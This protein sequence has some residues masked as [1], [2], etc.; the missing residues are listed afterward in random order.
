M[1][2]SAGFTLIELVVVI[3]LLG[4]LAAVAVPK[5]T[6]L[7][8]DARNAAAAG[9][10]GAI[11]SGSAINYGSYVAR[12]GPG[13]NGTAPYAVADT[14][15]NVCTLGTLGK[16]VTGGVVLVA[17]GATVTDKLNSTYFVSSG[18]N[19]CTGGGS[20]VTCGLTPPSDGGTPPTKQTVTVTCTGA[21]T[22]AATTQ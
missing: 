19:D 8:G 20:T 17:S 9:V 18:D 12:G 10:A 6:G 22:P 7:S 3:V 13:A 4:I 16:F 15:A 11:S 5:F 2:R 1:K 21:P 14:N